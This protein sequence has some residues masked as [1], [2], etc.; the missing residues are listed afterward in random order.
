MAEDK[1]TL[2]ELIWLYRLNQA[3]LL[4]EESGAE[5]LLRHGG[6]HTDPD[7]CPCL[8]WEECGCICHTRPCLGIPVYPS[9]PVS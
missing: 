2:Q 9:A 5:P 7:D 8:P 4:C 6:Y 3:P 1:T